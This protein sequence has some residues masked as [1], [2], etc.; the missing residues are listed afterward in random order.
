MKQIITFLN[1]KLKI[2]SNS[3]VNTDSGLRDL[4]DIKLKSM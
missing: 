4:S 3:K 1:E 2:N